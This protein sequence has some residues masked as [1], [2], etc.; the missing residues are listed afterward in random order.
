MGPEERFK[1]WEFPIIEE[2]KLNKYLWVVQN[3]DKFEL[4]Y[5]TDIGA[6]TYINAKFGVIIAINAPPRPQK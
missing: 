3:K 2:G 6:F 4:G 5:K 1:E